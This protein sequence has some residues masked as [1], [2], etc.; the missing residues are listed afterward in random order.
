MS[1]YSFYLIGHTLTGEVAQRLLTPK[2]VEQINDILSPS[3]DGLLSKAAL[4]ADTVKNNPK[5]K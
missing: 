4:W 2:T 5:F 3:F 1:V